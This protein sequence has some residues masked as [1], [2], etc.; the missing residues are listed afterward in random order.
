MLVEN[1]TEGGRTADAIFD[2][3]RQM[4]AIQGSFDELHPSS[5]SRIF[6]RTGRLLSGESVLVPPQPPENVLHNVCFW[7]NGFYH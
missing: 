3:A 7:N 1:P 2:Q 6:T 5:S 4:G